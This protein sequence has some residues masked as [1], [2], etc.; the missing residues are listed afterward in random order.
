MNRVSTP[1]PR[2]PCVDEQEVV[3]EAVAL[4]HLELAYRDAGC[5]AE[6][7]WSP[8]PEW[9]SPRP[10]GPHRLLAGFAFRGGAHSANWDTTNL[11]ALDG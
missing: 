8:G 11:T 6:G 1:V 9:P 7:S 2:R 5:G 10:R 4:N 3:G